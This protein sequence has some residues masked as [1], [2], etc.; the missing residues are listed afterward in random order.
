MQLSSLLYC[1]CEKRNAYVSV[2]E[3]GC[4]MRMGFVLR[5]IK[6]HPSVREQRAKIQVHL[7]EFL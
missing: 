5:E 6:R 7:K 1:T 3:I 2:A 4:D